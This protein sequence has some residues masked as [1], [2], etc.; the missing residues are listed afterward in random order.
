MSTRA[1]QAHHHKVTCLCLFAL[2]LFAEV[3]F[4]NQAVYKCGQEITNQPLDPKLCQQLNIS[5]P[6]QIDGTRVQPLVQKGLNA[7]SSD[8]SEASETSPLQVMP[9][10]TGPMNEASDRKAQARTILEDE[11]QK[12]TDQ[13]TELVRLYNRGQ[14]S[15]LSGETVHQ[16]SYQQ[17]TLALKVQLQ[18][19]ERDLQA[20]QRELGRYGVRMSIVQSK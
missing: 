4:A 11:W 3:T 19:V 5:Q 7:I 1:K 15:P 10:Q 20:L 12:L 18:R 14:P 16:S 17:R 9:T 13:Y 8:K 2:V 6:T